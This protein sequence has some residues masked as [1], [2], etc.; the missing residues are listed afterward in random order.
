MKKINFFLFILICSLFLGGCVQKSVIDDVNIATGIG[1]DKSGDQLLGS[2]MIP[3]FKPDKSFDNFTFIAKGNIM[4]DI[5]SE[6]QKK[7]S[8]PIVGGS[9]DLAFFGKDVAHEGIIQVLD[10]FLRDP[11]V[12][13]RVQ[14]AVVDGKA[15]DIFKG[16]YGDRGNAAY[17]TQLIEHN[18]TDQNLP[19]TNLHRFLAAFYQEGRDPY[20]PYLKKIKPYLV[21]ITGIALFKNGEIVDLLS[22]NKMFYFKLLVDKHTKGSVMVKDK[23]GESTVQSITSKTKIRMINRNPYEF[24]V[25]IKINGLLTEHQER[26]LKKDDIQKIEKQLEKQVNQECAKMI[27]QFQKKGIDP[28]GFGH[29]AK[30]RTRHFDFKKWNQLYKNARFKITSDVNI[31]EVGVVE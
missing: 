6:M 14:L 19:L 3:V 17:L 4:R 10:V 8:Q 23:S 1:I 7:A 20:L 5:V 26:T 27:E 24:T 12:G 25:N 29:F 16:K 9:L 30:T 31:I 13:S 18:M 28:V 15:I 21:S 11:S 2:I 22:E